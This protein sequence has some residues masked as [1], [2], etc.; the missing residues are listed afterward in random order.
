MSSSKRIQDSLP[1]VVALDSNRTNIS[2]VIN[3]SELV[4]DR[5]ENLPQWFP[6]T[7]TE[8]NQVIEA[9]LNN[10]QTA[11]DFKHASE[12]S[13][14]SGD[15][16]VDNIIRELT[17]DNTQ[18]EKQLNTETADKLPG[19]PPNLPERF[20]PNF[21]DPYQSVPAPEANAVTSEFEAAFKYEPVSFSPIR[22]QSGDQDWLADELVRE[23]RESMRKLYPDLD[24]KAVDNE[25]LKFM[26]GLAKLG[27]PPVYEDLFATL[28]TGNSVGVLAAGLDDDVGELGDFAANPDLFNE[29]A[30]LLV[31][32]E[33]NVKITVGPSTIGPRIFEEE[34]ATLDREAEE[35]VSEQL[36]LVTAAADLKQT[37]EEVLD[38]T[39]EFEQIQES[40]TSDSDVRYELSGEDPVNRSYEFAKENSFLRHQAEEALSMAKTLIVEAPPERL[41]DALE[42][43]LNPGPGRDELSDEKRALAWFNLGVVHAEQGDVYRATQCFQLVVNLSRVNADLEL[44]DSKHPLRLAA[45]ASVE[46]AILYG[47][48]GGMNTRLA[49]SHVRRWLALASEVRGE[50][51]EMSE[52]N[53]DV[54]DELGITDSLRQ[55]VRKFLEKN[56]GDA[57]ALKAA[58]LLHTLARDEERAM[59]A[60]YGVVDA[61]SKDALAW[62]RL[63]ERIGYTE[64]GVRARRK[65]VDLR[66]NDLRAWALVGVTYGEMEMW[67]KAAPYLLRA[68]VMD[69]KLSDEVE[70]TR[71]RNTNLKVVQN[72]WSSL[73]I[74]ARRLGLDELCG[75]AERREI[76]P[77]RAYFNF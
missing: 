31:P 39:D 54:D 71:K 46:L 26:D 16:A 57:D 75:A 56:T 45:T 8:I 23:Q 25:V 20:P 62:T 44:K 27:E 38:E 29:F 4:A 11:D 48:G 21:Y 35:S 49:L 33:D 32:K 51:V 65:V 52:D 50:G 63:A 40:R 34:W 9:S 13:D 55:S 14:G 58:S 70:R 69:K 7:P 30:E 68:L 64:D 74:C 47:V 12:V 66:P 5:T 36:D 18:N 73:G 59:D 10:I 42:A 19:T 41:I 17:E 60:L 43:A 6:R 72:A 77:F 3:A 53:V 22:A 28:A 76:E 15:T 61:S 24:D 1:A 2:R 37:V 67:D